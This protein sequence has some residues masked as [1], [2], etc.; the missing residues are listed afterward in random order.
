MKIKSGLII[1]LAAGGVAGIAQAEEFSPT[2][3]SV[4]Q[5]KANSEF[6]YVYANGMT[7]ERVVVERAT[8]VDVRG[9]GWT[10]DLSNTIDPCGVS[11]VPGFDPETSITWVCSACLHD[12]VA[13]AA[14][15]P[16]A[17]GS[18]GSWFDHPGDTI[19]NGLTFGTFNQIPDPGL[20]G[21]V[22]LDM[23]LVL[24]DNDRAPAA[25]RSNAVPTGV[26]L[27][28]ELNGA[29]D[30]DNSGDISFTEGN[31]WIYFFDFEGAGFDVEIGDTNGVY[32]GAFPDDG[33]FNPNAG[34]DVNGNGRINSGFH[35]FWRQPN[36][37][38]GDQ[39][40]D[41]WPELGGLGLENPDGLDP[42]TFPNILPIGMPLI[43][44]SS[45]L[46]DY[47]LPDPATAGVGE[48]PRVPGGPAS[49][50]S[51]AFDAFLILDAL[52]TDI[53]A[54]FF[55]GFKC[56]IA[57]AP[58]ATGPFYDPWSGPWMQ[59]NI[60][61]VGEPDPGCN[62]ADLAEPFGVLDLA[63]ISAFVTGFLAQ[64]PI[65]D[66]APPAGVWDLADVTAFVTAFQAGCP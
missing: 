65:A 39:I 54:F 33:L 20:D 35:F 51:G 43:S 7:G 12:P 29:E 27:F 24:T 9:A 3:I 60:N 17:V 19:I 32:D 62:D 52:G 49:Q 66:L 56:N 45:V 37:A 53:G 64:D 55:G 41:R 46:A 57:G 10:W 40:I 28:E 8:R 15:T 6:K 26:I 1:A 58:T 59:F 63:D 22:G 16:D 4:N 25:Q 21:V 61:G 13:G 38:E 31:I 18:W 14:I 48:W 23:I 42:N 34:V 44:P 5:Y 50:P 11:E 36:V 47:A 2:Q 30:L